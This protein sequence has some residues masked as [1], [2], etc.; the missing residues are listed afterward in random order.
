MMARSGVKLEC[1]CVGI[2]PKVH[3]VLGRWG[4]GILVEYYSPISG[5]LIV[6]CILQF[7]VYYLLL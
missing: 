3:V 6:S 4:V 2:F 7:L 5:S 1:R